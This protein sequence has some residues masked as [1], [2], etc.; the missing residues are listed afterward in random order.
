MGLRVSGFVSPWTG[1][2]VVQVVVLLLYFD[3]VLKMTPK[4]GHQVLQ[5]VV[6]D[7]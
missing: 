4:R 5:V 3:L 7:V 6:P 1:E 2:G